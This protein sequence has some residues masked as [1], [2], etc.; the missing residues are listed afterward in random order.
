MDFEGYRSQ[1]PITN[2]YTFMNHAA[3]SAPP[4]IVARAVQELLHEFTHSGISCYPKWMKRVEEVRGLA[5]QLI[6]ASPE[7]IA[8]TGNTSEGLSTVAAGL[9]WKNGD[10]ILVPRPEFPANVYPWMNLERRGVKVHFFDREDGRFDIGKIEQVLVPGTRLISVSSVDFATGYHCDLEALGDYCR[11][12]DLLLCV[13]AIQSLGVVPMDVKRCGIHFLAAGGHKWLLSTM[14]CGFLYISGEA[15][16]LLHPSRVGWKSVV[17]EED[18]FRVH[19]DLKPDA[20]R[21]ESGSMNVAGI[22]ALGAAMDLIMEVGVENIF[23]RITALNDA[24]IR[25][26]QDRNERIITPL[27]PGERSGIVSF[28]PS[29]DPKALYDYLS[30]EHMAVSLRNDMIRLSPHFYNNMD[31]IH[32]FFEVLDR[33]QEQN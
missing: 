24:L 8:F 5:S 26:L 22:Y 19:F 10:S 6:K 32:R 16:G 14:G 18:F 9:Q 23:R 13:D 1:F 3:I 29:S 11:R 21:F 12:K 17:E 2:T 30:Q 20:L 28:V 31:D 4:V 33:F 27:D 25:G 15:D 7:E